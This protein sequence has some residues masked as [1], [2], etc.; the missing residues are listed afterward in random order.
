MP[1]RPADTP[2]VALDVGGSS[3]KSGCV[4]AGRPVGEVA[5]TALD[6]DA[7]LEHL[8]GVF[9]A[10]IE[11]VAPAGTPDEPLRVATAMPDPFDHAAGVSWMAHKFAALRGRRLGPL[12]A[13]ALGRPIEARWC[14]DAAA[15][16]AGEAAAGAGA[17]CRTVLGVT[18]GTGL[19]A[20]LTRDGAV[21]DATGPWVV[22][23]LWQ[24]TLPDGRSADTAFAAR[25]LLAA[26]ASGDAARFGYDLGEFVAPVVAAA[27]ADVVVV[28]GGGAGSF[29]A[30]AEAI[31][32]TVPVPVVAARLGA[33]AA[34]LGAAA[35]CWNPPTG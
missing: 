20:A 9:V 13:G 2:I 1:N 34:V 24:A 30:F 5:V 6:R 23:D 25:T 19:G 14:N 3:I 8:V 17:G 15:A 16:V 18:L 35:L 12:L 26:I 32:S 10:A 4:R 31:R 7:D 28:G 27:R 21:V 29:D 22:G 33:W 11:A